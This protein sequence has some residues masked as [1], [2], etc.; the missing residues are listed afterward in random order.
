MNPTITV[1]RLLVA[2]DDPRITRLLLRVA[3]KLGFETSAVS[4]PSDFD[5]TY[6]QVVPDIILLDLN[7]P[8]VDGVELLQRLSGWGANSAI[9]LM[10][11]V[12]SQVLDATVLLGNELGLNMLDSL[13]KPFDIDEL[14]IRL[15]DLQS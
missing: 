2:D 13:A 11:G 7:M 9:L 8:G 4:D 6:A 1:K 10:S 5:R 14:R 3:R 12:G 15:S